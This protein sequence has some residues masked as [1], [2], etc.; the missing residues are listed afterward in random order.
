MNCKRA[1]G[2]T[3]YSC[4]ILAISNAS[5]LAQLQDMDS[6]RDGSGKLQFRTR[7]SSSGLSRV[8]VILKRNGDA[9]I[10]VLAGTSATISGKWRNSGDRSVKIEIDRVDRDRADGSGT[11][12]HNGRGEFTRISLSGSVDRTR[13]DLDF[14]A[15][16]SG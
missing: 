13:F 3:I 5:A 7:S 2:L 8:K 15:S 6:T 14:T 10:R 11:I 9:E 4:V 16:S 12:E 1:L